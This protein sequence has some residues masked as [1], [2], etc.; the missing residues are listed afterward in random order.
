M[1]F[2]RS[3][4]TK[5]EKTGPQVEWSV[6]DQQWVPV[7]QVFTGYDATFLRSLGWDPTKVVLS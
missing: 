5:P 2:K 3:I 6:E 4:K 1:A 7:R